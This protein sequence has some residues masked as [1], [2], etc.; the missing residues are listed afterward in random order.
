[1]DFSAE[2]IKPKDCVSKPLNAEIKNYKIQNF[3]SSRNIFSEMR[4]NEDRATAKTKNSLPAL[5]VAVKS[6]QL[7]LTLCDPIADML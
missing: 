5:A 7:C 1:M 4:A 6:L 2:I 3:I